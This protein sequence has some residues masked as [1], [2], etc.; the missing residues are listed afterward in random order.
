[1]FARSK[2]SIIEICDYLVSKGVQCKAF[3]FDLNIH[4]RDAILN[5]FRNN[6]LKVLITSDVLAHGI[7]IP[8]AYLVINLKTPIK[9]YEKK[10]SF[11]SNSRRITVPDCDT[12]FY[13][14]GRAGRFG[15]EGL[16]FT[17]VLGQNDEN[18]LKSF[19]SYKNLNIPLNFIS[20]EQITRL[21]EEI[22]D[23]R[24]IP[25]TSQEI[26]DKDDE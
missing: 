15:R 16:C 14:C 22:S 5:Q 17:F 26:V 25:Q 13:R 12:Y 20:K 24:T 8:Y 9:I 7:D 2:K 19:C 3:T 11:P 6:E 18:N 23:E 21:P 10:S 1:M 4:E